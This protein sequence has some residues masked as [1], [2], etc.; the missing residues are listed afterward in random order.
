[1]VFVIV[2]TAQARFPATARVHL[3]EVVSSRTERNDII[4]IVI[5]VRFNYVHQVVEA[6]RTCTT[7][8]YHVVV[9][10]IRRTT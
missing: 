6:Q 3:I 7:Y 9:I 1:V 8:I 2:Y 10:R 5:E 4:G